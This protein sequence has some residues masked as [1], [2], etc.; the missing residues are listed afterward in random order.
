M[1][2]KSQTPWLSFSLRLLLRPLS[3]ISLDTWDL[4]PLSHHHYK[5]PY[6][7]PMEIYTYLN[8]CRKINETDMLYVQFVESMGSTALT[9]WMEVAAHY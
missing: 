1:K 9:R 7:L 3:D 6:M 5:R 4:A 2:R 8:Y